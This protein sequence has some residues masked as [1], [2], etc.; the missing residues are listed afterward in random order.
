MSYCKIHNTN[1][2]NSSCIACE[3]A[4]QTKEIVAAID[5]LQLET[6]PVPVEGNR[7]KPTERIHHWKNA[8]GKIIEHKYVMG[9]YH[10]CSIPGCPAK[11]SERIIDIGKY[12]G[13][14]GGTVE[15]EI[16]LTLFQRFKKWWY[17]I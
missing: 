6:P 4:K 7:K 12:A 13:T 10:Y 9:D 11:I 5:R 14:Y 15:K 2:T 8:D 3:L 1:T 17:M 16:P